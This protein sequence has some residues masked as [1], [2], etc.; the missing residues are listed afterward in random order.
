MKFDLQMAPR[1]IAKL[2][3]VGS[4][5]ERNAELRGLLPPSALRLINTLRVSGGIMPAK[6][7]TPAASRGLGARAAAPAPEPAAA[8]THVPLLSGE[9]EPAAEQPPP[10]PI[11]A[12]QAS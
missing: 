5:Y 9:A 12:P 6:A 8:A 4:D 1:T 11:E 3:V 2:M 7:A 10:P